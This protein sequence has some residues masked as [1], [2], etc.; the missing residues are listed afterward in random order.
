MK[1]TSSRSITTVATPLHLA[2][3]IVAF[4]VVDLCPLLLA[5]VLLLRLPIYHPP[6]S[7]C[8]PT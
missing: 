7:H 3:H 5:L 1:E 6:G 4:V 2:F 8:S